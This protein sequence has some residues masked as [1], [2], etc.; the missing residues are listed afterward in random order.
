MCSL[1]LLLRAVVYAGVLCAYECAALQCRLGRHLLG[2]RVCA[3]SKPTPVVV[4]DC[5]I[6]P[7]AG[8][9]QTGSSVKCASCVSRQTRRRLGPASRSGGCL[10]WE[11]VGGEQV[12][13]SKR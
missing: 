11:E 8:C 7:A 9:P 10:Q 1:G 12:E 2:C 3:P 5:I 4:R 6:S 13:L